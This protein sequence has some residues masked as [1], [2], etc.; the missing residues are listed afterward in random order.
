MFN[1][2]YPKIKILKALTTTSKETSFFDLN[3]IIKLR[4]PKRANRNL[5]L[6]EVL[7]GVCVKKLIKSN[8]EPNI[9]NID[10]CTF[11][12]S[13]KGLKELQDNEEK[14]LQFWIPVF[15]SILA[16]GISMASL[17]LEI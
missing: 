17:L 3:K 12:I 5:I 16:V 4:L 10:E 15:I 9:K 2:Y 11:M 1:N 7:H 8:K 6:I 14:A 13:D